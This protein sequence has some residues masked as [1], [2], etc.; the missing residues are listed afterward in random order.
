MDRIA[1]FIPPFGLIATRDKLTLVRGDSHGEVIENMYKAAPYVKAVYVFTQTPLYSRISAWMAILLSVGYKNIKLVNATSWFNTELMQR[2]PVKWVVGECVALLCLKTSTFTIYQKTVDGYAQVGDNVSCEVTHF[3]KCPALK[4]VIVYAASEV[5]DSDK[6]ALKNGFPRQTVHFIGNKGRNWLKCIWD[7]YD[8]KVENFLPAIFTLI[9]RF[10][11][12]NNYHVENVDYSQLPYEKT[13]ELDIEDARNLEP[14]VE[15][16]DALQADELD[17]YN[18]VAGKSRVLKITYEVGFAFIPEIFVTVASEKDTVKGVVY[19]IDFV[20]NRSYNDDKPDDDST[21]VDN[22]DYFTGTLVTSDGAA[23]VVKRSNDI[24]DVFKQLG[25]KKGSAKLRGVFVDYPKHI[26]FPLDAHR[27]VVNALPSPKTKVCVGRTHSEW[28]IHLRNSGVKLMLGECVIV[29]NWITY[30]GP[31]KEYFHLLNTENGFQTIGKYTGELPDVAY[32]KVVVIVKRMESG[33][34]DV[35]ESLFPSKK[36]VFSER[37]KLPKN[38]R[39]DFAWQYFNGMNFYGYL[40]LP[41]RGMFFGAISGMH[42]DKIDTTCSYNCGT[43]ESQIACLLEKI[44]NDVLFGRLS[45]HFFVSA[46]YVGYKEGANLINIPM[47]KS[48]FVHVK[49]R[50]DDKLIPAVTYTEADSPLFTVVTC[51]KSVVKKRKNASKSQND[52]KNLPTK[53]TVAF[54]SDSSETRSVKSVSDGY[55][56]ASDATN[57]AKVDCPSEFR[58]SENTQITSDVPNVQLPAVVLTFTE[59]NQVLIMAGTDY[60]GDKEISAY[61]R[62]KYTNGTP[63]FLVGAKAK[64]TTKKSRKH[65]I[66]DIPGL[67]AANSKRN[68][69]NTTWAFETSRADDGSLLIHLNAKDRTSPVVAFGHIVRSVLQHVK[70]NLPAMLDRVGI[71]L[72]SEAAISMEDLSAISSKLGVNLE[73][74]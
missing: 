70:N 5:P 62:L 64:E 26:I 30:H 17:I 37:S 13:F 57:A 46:N 7:E 59:N 45:S 69:E 65:L 22:S 56:A 3:D 55:P 28:A 66:Y 23:V 48:T 21:S 40:V 39:H 15:Y 19:S 68:C 2:S 9:L 60:T 31:Y 58:V 63:E 72:P 27:A 11:Y 24:S 29:T 20:K 12:G 8:G 52:E 35:A 61:L 44:P 18:F 1:L 14:S 73:L 16:S 42:G 41:F 71:R 43:Y 54:G 36:V 32:D 49:A 67:L 47:P 10:K 6:A 38:V 74:L 4:H 53:A 34:K 50:I 33:F 51:K 25:A